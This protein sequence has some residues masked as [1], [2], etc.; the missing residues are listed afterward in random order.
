MEE[1][2]NVSSVSDRQVGVPAIREHVAGL[3][4][5]LLERL[6]GIGATVATPRGEGELGPL[7][8]VV[9][10]DPRALV[11]ALKRAGVVTSERDAN[12]RI[13][14]HLYNVREDVDRIVDALSANSELLS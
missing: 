13:S 9:S 10:T 4:G 14:L 6:D 1:F 5:Y 3:V 11:E 12:V 2:A 8:C 7:V